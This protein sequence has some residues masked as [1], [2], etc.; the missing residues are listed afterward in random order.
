MTAKIRAETPIFAGV[1]EPHPYVPQRM[2]LLA[3]SKKPGLLGLAILAYGLLCAML[4]V[5]NTDAGIAAAVLPGLA[6]VLLPARFAS[7]AALSRRA[8]VAWILLIVAACPWQSLAVTAYGEVN[9]GSEA[10]AAKFVVTALACL[11]AY[12]ARVPGIKYPWPIKAL[13]GYA[14]V[15]ALGGLASTDPSSSLL[16]SA[17]FAIVVIAVVWI[18]SRLSR[19]RIAVLFIQFSVSVSL[20][21]LMAR[22]ADLPSS[23]LFG[24]RLD[25]YLLPLQPNALG[26]IAAGGLIC[27]TALLAQK[28][29]TLRPFALAAAILGITLIL[30]ESR[31]STIGFLLCLLVLAGPKLSTRGPI[32]LG[33]LAFALLA[34]AFLQTDTGSQPLT[35]LLTHNGSTTTTATL[36]SR[37]SEWQAAL[38]INNTAFKQAVGQGLATKSVQVGLKSAQ[39]APVDGSWPATYLSAGLFGVLI[40]AMAV[41]TTAR[42]AVQQRDDL[43]MMVIAYLII[44][45]LVTDVFNDISVGLILFISLGVSLAA[46]SP[47]ANNLVSHGRLQSDG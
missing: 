17:R 34:V 12:V 14:L 33:L 30:T 15:T 23:H 25:G 24:N 47:P 6:V 38:Q 26:L 19:S 9:A 20:L 35:S 43:A 29:L 3:V 42:T 8:T 36:G 27:A 37:E 31:T 11:L 41:I 39:Y 16:R 18:T 45:S 46:S 5:R 32:I 21:A 40:L 4:L 2:A 28:Q 1:A 13:L 7:T 22:A 10:D 44:S